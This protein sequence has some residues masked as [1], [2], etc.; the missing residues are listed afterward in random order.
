MF[1]RI[2]EIF[3]L[4]H[5][6]RHNCPN[7][8]KISRAFYDDFFIFVFLNLYSHTPKL[9]RFITPAVHQWLDR[10]TLVCTYIYSVFS[11]N[12]YENFIFSQTCSISN[13]L[14]EQIIFFYEFPLLSTESNSTQIR[15][16]G[17]SCGKIKKTTPFQVTIS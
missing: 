9:P 17:L 16:K 3:S 14:H 15:K 2:V 11:F 13:K 7:H 6:Y 5:G 12:I 4:I 8:G 10:L 1:S